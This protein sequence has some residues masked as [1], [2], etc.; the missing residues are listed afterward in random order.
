MRDYTNRETYDK[1]RGMKEMLNNS[2]R[3][4]VK[5]GSTLLVDG[6]SVLQQPWLQGLLRDVA[7]Y[8][9]AGKQVVI[10]TSG[11]VALGRKALGHKPRFLEERQAAAAI[12]QIQLVQAYQVGLAIHGITVGQLLLTL[13]DSEDRQRY[14]NA[15]NTLETLISNR[16]VP[17]INE[18]D[19]V[20]TTEIRYGDN[21]RLA[22]RVAQ[23]IA[24]DV[25]ILL[26]DIDGLYTADPRRYDAATF[27]PEVTRIDA[28]IEAMA[29]GSSS[30]LGSGGMRTKI[31]AG[32]IMMS[33][34][35]KMVIVK[36]NVDHPLRQLDYEGPCTW[37]LPQSTPAQ[38]RKNWL[39]QHLNPVGELMVDAGA[40]KALARGSSL[41]AVGVTGVQGEFKKGACV[42]I[43]SADGR[44]IGRGLCNY[45]AH[46]AKKILGKHSEELAEFLGYEGS[47]EMIH[48]ND[49]ALLDSR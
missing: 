47:E 1:L 25:L 37:F 33:A 42:R 7:H 18:N 48:R 15:R 6:D 38:A 34:G 30:D 4:V 3:I 19:T 29:A 41:L 20:A 40:E 11:A 17:V 16:I 28:D 45:P 5:V 27:I 2:Q 10:V 44:D 12:G 26:S 23:M 32:K 8:H 14:L 46:E 22:A 35:G 24:A 39:R 43:I 13:D 9:K 49:L 31:A 21:D 36:G